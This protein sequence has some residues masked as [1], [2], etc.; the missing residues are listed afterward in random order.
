MHRGLGEM[1]HVNALPPQSTVNCRGEGAKSCR[2]LEQVLR[3]SAKARSMKWSDIPWPCAVAPVGVA[4]PEGWITDVLWQV[5]GWFSEGSAAEPR[6]SM[7][8]VYLRQDAAMAFE[9][10]GSLFGI[11]SEGTA[12]PSTQSSHHDLGSG[13]MLQSTSCI[14]AR[15]GR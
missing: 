13:S 15:D 8:Y 5:C 1:G 11:G 4:M 7:S 3:G 12:G 2:V 10:I 14:E 6:A 9:R